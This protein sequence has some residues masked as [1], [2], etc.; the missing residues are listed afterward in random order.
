MS[1]KN[2]LILYYKCQSIQSNLD[3]FHNDFEKI[4]D[5]IESMKYRPEKRE[6][7]NNPIINEPN[8][9]SFHFFS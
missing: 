6:I 7:K 8:T 2:L 4:K 9:I 3:R 5:N 1:T